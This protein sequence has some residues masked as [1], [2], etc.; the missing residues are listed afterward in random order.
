MHGDTI[1]HELQTAKGHGVNAQG[2]DKEHVWLDLCW[3]AL[4]AEQAWN[5]A[6]LAK[7][8]CITKCR[9]AV[10]FEAYIADQ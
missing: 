9:H 4:A 10:C 8:S 3:G 5:T 1:Q 6:Q 2:M 7:Y